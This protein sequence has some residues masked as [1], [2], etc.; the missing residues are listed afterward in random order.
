MSGADVIANAD[1]LIE[2]SKQLANAGKTAE[3]VAAAQRAVDLLRGVG[4]PTTAEAGY[5][6]ELGRAL[7]NL[8][9]RLWGAGCYDEMVGPA[10]E[11]A[12][13]F[14]VLSGGR[15]DTLIIQS[16][17]S[18]EGTPMII[19]QSSTIVSS[20]NSARETWARSRSCSTVSL[21]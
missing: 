9:Y 7:Q 20:A 13:V 12:Q 21:Q 6:L 5:R 18:P 16:I 15:I 4:P 10:K 11:A 3:A 14:R 1:H 17:P 8:A 2:L 19:E